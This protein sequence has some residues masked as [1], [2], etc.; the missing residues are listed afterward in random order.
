MVSV[1]VLHHGSSSALPSE[2]SKH[3]AQP[4]TIQIVTN[5]HE[6][7][8]ALWKSRK[9]HR[10]HRS[11]HFQHQWPILQHILLGKGCRALDRQGVHSINTQPCHRKQPLYMALN[12]EDSLSAT[13]FLH[14]QILAC[15]AARVVKLLYTKVQHF[16]TMTFHTMHHFEAGHPA[17]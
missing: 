10:Q 15:V 17:K 16:L 4:L 2:R 6:R 9:A 3:S 11:H 5:A 12:T 13:C 14:C 7:G 8:M 1:S